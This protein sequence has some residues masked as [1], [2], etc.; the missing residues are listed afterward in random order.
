MSATGRTKKAGAP[1]AREK[2]DN[3]ET[4]A[5]CVHAI[6]PHVRPIQG[7]VLDPTCGRG[8]IFEALEGKIEKHR[9]FGIEI[10]VGRAAQAKY[11]A[12]RVIHGDFL[13]VAPNPMTF[14][15][16]NDVLGWKPSLILT[17]PPYRPALSIVQRSLEIVRPHGGEVA[18]LLRVNFLGS[19][20]RGPWWVDHLADMYVLSERPSFTAALRWDAQ[21]AERCP[22]REMKD[23]G[24]WGPRCQRPIEHDGDCATYGTD[25]TEYCW[26]VW[27]PHRRGQIHIL[28]PAAYG[29]E[30]WRSAA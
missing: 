23:D 27:G 3:Y 17:N 28:P 10:D 1:T 26:F 18:M 15:G 14:Q 29:R 20:E 11:R 13:E 2:D 21:G 8:A 9:L 5:W 30:N 25:A 24:K 7:N 19:Q 22:N 4:P 12:H 16:A 6:W